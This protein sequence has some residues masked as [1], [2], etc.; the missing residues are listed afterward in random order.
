MIRK[1]IVGLEVN[2]TTI[3]IIQLNEKKEVLV[4]GSFELPEGV[5]SE[6]VIVDKKQFVEQCMSFFTHTKPIALEGDFIKPYAIVSLPENKV[7][8]HTFI[9]PSEILPD[10][11]SAYVYTEASKLIPVDL[12]ELYTTYSA[13]IIRGTCFV[14]FVGARKDIV[15]AYKNCLHEAGLEVEFIGSNFY[16]IARAVLP[17]TFGTDNYIII[18]IGATTATI[19]AFDET[20]I[21]Y[22]TRQSF[23]SAEQ[24]QNGEHDT[25]AVAMLALDCATVVASF[26]KNTGQ[27][28]TQ[29]ILTGHTEG[30]TDCLTYLQNAL[31]LKVSLCNTYRHLRDI[32]VIDDSIQPGSFANV[33]GLALYGVDRTMPHIN[34]LPEKSQYRDRSFLARSKNQLGFL[35][36]IISAVQLFFKTK[37]YSTPFSLKNAPVVYIFFICSLGILAYVLLRYAF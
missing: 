28:I 32:S 26:E 8:S 7:W 19:G 33:V 2:D 3:N 18:D 1:N 25:S 9:I 11:Y 10:E 21:A 35:P 30:K 20:A 37:K 23:V 17:K 34:L 29:V 27:K 4:Y 24:I 15:E 31:H 22:I 6:G 16:S 5:V 36:S 13:K 14:T 12:S